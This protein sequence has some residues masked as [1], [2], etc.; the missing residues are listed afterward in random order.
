M[1]ALFW[2]CS[3]DE[4]DDADPTAGQGGGSGAAGRAGT[5]G[6]GGTAES[7]R[8]GGTEAG[9]AGGEGDPAGG[10]GEGGT[11]DAA[12]A[13]GSGTD[14]GG[15]AGI[16]GETGGGGRAGASGEAGA[17]GEGGSTGATS[18]AACLACAN[19]CEDEL[20]RCESSPLCNSWLSCVRACDR[21]GCVEDCDDTYGTAP[22]LLDAVY[23]CLCSSDCEAECS[24]AE[25][26]DKSCEDDAGLPVLSN[27]PPEKLSDT[28]LYVEAAGAEPWVIAPYVRTFEPEYELWADGAVKQRYIYLPRCKPITSSD[29]DH[30]SFPV[31]TRIW[32]QFTRD[33]V[34]IETR[35]LARFGT[36]V[37]DWLTVSYQWPL[38]ASVGGELDPE[39]A[40]PAP[41]AGVDAANGTEH[42]IPSRG[43]CTQCHGALSERV[44]GFSAIQLS[45]PASAGTAGD[46]TFSELA[47]KGVLSHAPVRTGYDPPGSEVAKAALGYL[48]ANCG[49]CHNETGTFTQSP[50]LWLRL[51]VGQTTVETTHVYTSAVGQNTGNPNFSTYK[52]IAPHHANQSST[53][54]RMQRNPSLGEILPMP[55][56]GR[57]LPDM[58]GVSVVSAWINS[59]PE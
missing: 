22:I 11:P 57:R 14:G 20:E 15:Q 17:G 28:G 10:G 42:R 31:G 35:L 19:E 51:L 39:T 56:I 38:P 25:V 36:G 49:N 43:E 37:A 29:M 40:L 30:W 18:G 9:R 52:R 23:A 54:L 53:I 5:G 24:V 32:K 7:G 58:A 41:D 21:A 6:Q 44:L 12:G 55:P 59:L 3:S 47:D 4:G 26:C 45:Y 1:L 46:L 27:T 48:H 8:G 2:A 50:S 13:S 34:R 16:G 33:G